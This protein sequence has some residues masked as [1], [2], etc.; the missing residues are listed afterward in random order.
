LALWLGLLAIVRFILKHLVDRPRRALRVT[1]EREARPSVARSTHLMHRLWDKLVSFVE[2][3][4]E[5]PKRPIIVV[6][7]LYFGAQ[8]LAD[9]LS[10]KPAVKFSS[11]E[12][13][14]ES[15]FVIAF[16]NAMGILLLPL[17]GGIFGAF[18][19]MVLNFFTK[20]PTLF[21]Y[22]A[23][24]PPLQNEACLESFIQGRQEIMGYAAALDEAE[25]AALGAETIRE[26]RAPLSGQTCLAFRIVGETDDQPVDDADAA[27]FAV[28][29]PDQKRCVVTNADVVVSLTG[30]TKVRAE[31]AS[32][33]LGERGLPEKDIAVREG[34]LREGDLVRVFGQ[35]AEIR[36]GSAGYRGDE[37]RMMLDASDG[38]PV[39]I[40]APS[41]APS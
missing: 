38:K 28:V 6:L 29:T 10:E 7:V 22:D 32:G 27:S 3:L 37:R 16:V 36:V 18:L 9:I 24:P 12:A 34:V 14:G 21:G 41:D 31:N 11:L 1:I 8:A 39:V 30:S 5:S 40:L 4:I 2:R 35:R 17:F 19:T 20:P 13:F 33:F 15:M 23:T 26:V 25:R